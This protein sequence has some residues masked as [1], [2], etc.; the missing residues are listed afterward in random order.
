MRK[1]ILIC[2]LLCSSVSIAADT[3]DP[4]LNYFSILSDT[5][6]VTE[7][8]DTVFVEIHARDD[9]SGL[10]MV[11][12]FFESPS[13]EKMLL[14]MN[15][16]TPGA[17]SDSCVVGLAVQPMTESG[18]WTLTTLLLTDV[19][20]NQATF[21]STDMKT[22]GF[23]YKLYVNSN[24]DVEPPLLNDF[25]FLQ[26]TIEVTTE[27]ETVSYTVHASDSLSGLQAVRVSLQSP[28]GATSL[29]S[30]AIFNQ[31]S[32]NDTA[33]GIFVLQ[34]FTESGDW[35]VL[36]ISLHDIMGNMIH[37]TAEQLYA[38]GFYPKVNVQAGETD[39]QAPELIDFVFEPGTVELN[40]ASSDTVTFQIIARDD[41]SGLSNGLVYFK[42]IESA[43][44]VGASVMFT[45]GSLADTITGFFTL[46]GI[47]EP[48][49]WGVDFLCLI[50]M[51]GNRTVFQQKDLMDLGFDTK[52]E[53]IQNTDV[54][55]TGS[56]CEFQLMQNYPNPFNP[57][58]RIEYSLP[59]SEAVTF[60]LY[61]LIGNKVM[62]KKLGHQTAGYHVFHLNGSG[63]TS[64][65]YFY[66]IK[67]GQYKD[68][69]RCL[70]LR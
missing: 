27:G 56:S 22:L 37:Y 6:D 70:L 68:M 44:S 8:A 26:D 12:F 65:I 36:E 13:A 42:S 32:P 60:S 29:Q 45:A 28:S 34:P 59:K 46:D 57:T 24:E 16:F 52:L 64:G 40:S 38:F 10:N 49:E 11:R 58:T 35:E 33:E 31:G 67:S 3:N 50:D 43:N 30:M 47:T 4:V 63:L 5:V 7:T 1:V 61:N 51:A 15:T 55:L 18:D 66:Q 62:H 2:I 20:G 9:S 17:L 39:I 48:G 54:S 21:D 53:I 19:D 69:K 41:V 23:S 14:A 25:A